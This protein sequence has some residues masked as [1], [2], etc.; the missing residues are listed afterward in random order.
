MSEGGNVSINSISFSQEKFV[1]CTFPHIFILF[2]F[3][4]HTLFHVTQKK[5][6]T[7]ARDSILSPLMREIRKSLT[8]LVNSYL[9]SSEWVTYLTADEKF[10]L[11]SNFFLVSVSS[12]RPTSRCSS[13]WIHTRCT[14]RAIV[15]A[16]SSIAYSISNRHWYRYTISRKFKWNKKIWNLKK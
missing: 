12:T 5:S 2:F 9:S 15:R 1:S 16:S 7:L 8:T 13:I 3:S 11:C 14:V 10:R 4:F 6:D